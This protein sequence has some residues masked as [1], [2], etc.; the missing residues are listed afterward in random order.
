MISKFASNNYSFSNVLHIYNY[1]HIAA[2][3]VAVVN[4]E[5]STKSVKEGDAVEICVVADGTYVFTLQVYITVVANEGTA[6]TVHNE[7]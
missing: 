7:V 6:G 1:S 4:F 3:S 2:P 5:M